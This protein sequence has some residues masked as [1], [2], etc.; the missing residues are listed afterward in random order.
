MDLTLL[1]PLFEWENPH[2]KKRS[3]PKIG[4]ASF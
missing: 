4:A 1:D 3:R 2:K